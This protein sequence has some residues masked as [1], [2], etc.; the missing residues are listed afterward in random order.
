MI[1]LINVVINNSLPVEIGEYEISVL[2]FNPN[3]KVAF[4]TALLTINDHDRD[5]HEEKLPTCL[6]FGWNEYFTCKNCD[7]TA[8]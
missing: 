3:Y 4:N 7:Y 8:V 5:Y 2:A 1:K 6:E